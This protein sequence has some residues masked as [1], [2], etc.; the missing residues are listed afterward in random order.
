MRFSN[1]KSM[2]GKLPG[3]VKYHPM[4]EIPDLKT[5]LEKF[6]SRLS[7]VLDYDSFEY[8]YPEL[9]VHLCV[10]R[11]ERHRCSYTIKTA[12]RQRGEIVMTRKT[13]F[14]ESE[15]QLFERHLA[16]L[17]YQLEGERP[18]SSHT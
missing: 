10:G 15:L 3:R 13:P 8:L 12:E 5:M 16:V 2:R 7:S 1:T 4:I 17:A 11:L 18:S 14:M 6:E 9:A